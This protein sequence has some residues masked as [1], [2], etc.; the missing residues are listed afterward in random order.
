[1]AACTN[2]GEP[3]GFM[4]TVC[5][6]CI[7]RM[8]QATQDNE[9]ARARE[10]AE[11]RH[12]LRAIR[13]STSDSIPGSAMSAVLDIVTADCVLGADLLRDL[14]AA[15][16]HFTAGRSGRM[17]QS[18]R[19]ARETCILELRAAAKLLGANAI[20]GIR[21]ECNELSGAGK[22]MLAVAATGTAVLVTHHEG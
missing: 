4:S 2:C 1:M 20:V 18:L 5:G 12:E 21:F 19:E 7:V 17:E 22:N 11:Y 6:T 3:A 9:S 14:S 15:A 8:D 10:E 13:C 16:A